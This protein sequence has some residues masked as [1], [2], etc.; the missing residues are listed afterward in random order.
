M[1]LNQAYTTC[2]L[3]GGIFGLH[4]SLVGSNMPS[5][6][7]TSFSETPCHLC[8]GACQCWRP[9]EFRRRQLE[10]LVLLLGLLASLLL[11]LLTS[12]RGLYGT[13]V[14][15]MRGV[16]K[17]GSKGHC[18]GQRSLGELGEELEAES[19]QCGRCGKQELEV[20]MG[21]AWGCFVFVC[22]EGPGK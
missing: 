12:R 19:Q 1:G 2:S 6:G 18:P 17:V 16:W 10:L 3:S 15:K 9:G 20:N 8:Q 7:A 14:E 5:Q 22:G 13:K 4:Q 11:R 21:I